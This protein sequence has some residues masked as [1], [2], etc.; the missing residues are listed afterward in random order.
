MRKFWEKFVEISENF[1]KNLLKFLENFR[2]RMLQNFKENFEGIFCFSLKKMK[3]Y[4]HFDEIT[5]KSVKKLPR[6]YYENLK[7]LD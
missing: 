5:K 6:K 3:I 7:K 1:R 4:K 2:E